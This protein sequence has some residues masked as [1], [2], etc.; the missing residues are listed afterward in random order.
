MRIKTQ[1]N[2]LTVHAKHEN[3]S[4]NSTIL[5]EYHRQFTLP[6]GIETERMTSL[7]SP[8]GVLTIEAPLPT[9]TAQEETP[10]SIPIEHVEDK[11]K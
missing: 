6:E 7:L 3:K 1:N 11:E 10:K 9:S 4:E 2:T 5:R 8:D